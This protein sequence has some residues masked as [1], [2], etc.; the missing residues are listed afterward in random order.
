[1]QQH[2]QV[3]LMQTQ[4][5]IIANYAHLIVLHAFNWEITALLVQLQIYYLIIRVLL[6]AQVVCTLILLLA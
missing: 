4:Q 2:A 6:A 1:M 3:V 5:I